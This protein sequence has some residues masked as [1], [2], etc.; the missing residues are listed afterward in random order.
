MKMA[1]ETAASSSP[2]DYIAAGEVR[3]TTGEGE[4]PARRAMCMGFVLDH[5]GQKGNGGQG[6]LSKAY[7]VYISFGHCGGRAFGAVRPVP[8]Q[9]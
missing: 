1:E 8:K 7:D 3:G 5:R 9:R 6:G 2:A 4:K